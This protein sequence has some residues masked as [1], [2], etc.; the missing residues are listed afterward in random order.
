MNIT[1]SNLFIDYFNSEIQRRFY[2]NTFLITKT[3]LNINENEIKEIDTTIK[4]EDNDKNEYNPIVYIYNTHETENYKN[5]FKSEYS[6]TPDVKLAS[7]ILKDYLNDYDID[8]YVETKSTIEYVKKN[9]LSYTDTYNASRKYLKEIIKKYDFK[10]II[11]LHRDSVSK[12]LI[13][14]NKRYAKIMIVIG[15]NHKNYKKNLL[16]A[17][18]INKYLNKNLKGISRGIYEKPKSKFNQDIKDNIILIEMG[19]VDNTL[20]EINNSIYILAKS[21]RDYII[22]EE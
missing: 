11:D 18:K 20:E 7:Y 2:R 6:I 9:N 10:I 1:K 19:G 14:D 8:S 4:D 22:N 5:E 16:L 21:I 15:E 3:S 17:N 13:K 12:T